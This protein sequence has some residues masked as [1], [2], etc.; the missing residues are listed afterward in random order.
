MKPLT[1]FCLGALLCVSALSY[2]QDQKGVAEGEYAVEVKPSPNNKL[3]G[4]NQAYKDVITLKDGKF[5]TMVNTKY[6][7]DPV[8]YEV[9]TDGGKTVV[10]AE[11]KDEKHGSNKYELEV[12][13]AAL[14]GTMKWGKMGEDGKPKAAEY[15]LT[16]A[17][18]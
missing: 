7:F 2:A 8:A 4:T 16:G 9:K 10:V 12:K 17:K 14:E 11:L 3:R 5:S 13:G 15:T 1:L 18:K 6:G